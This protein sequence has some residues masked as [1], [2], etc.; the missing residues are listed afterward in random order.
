ME[1]E[2]GAW[3]GVGQD[4]NCPVSGLAP[5][6]GL[7]ESSSLSS[8]IIYTDF[9]A[10]TPCKRNQNWLG[11][12]EILKDPNPYE[13]GVKLTNFI[14][15]WQRGELWLGQKCC[16]HLLTQNEGL[17]KRIGANMWQGGHICPPL[18]EMFRKIIWGWGQASLFSEN[19]HW[20][21][22]PDPTN[23]RIWSWDVLD[24]GHFCIWHPGSSFLMFLYPGLS[25]KIPHVWCSETFGKNQE[26]YIRFWTFLK[27]TPG[28]I[29]FDVHVTRAFWKYTTCMVFHDVLKNPT[30]P[31]IWS[32]AHETY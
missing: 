17:S 24:F 27:L 26:Y 3:G 15:S 14:F 23:A 16:T 19:V 25:E 32:W 7:P 13:S 22:G 4:S 6:H 18:L 21:K 30:N 12:Y 10:P 28:I 8:P 2:L 9:S 31:R 1:G 29:I 11:V 5:D 20:W